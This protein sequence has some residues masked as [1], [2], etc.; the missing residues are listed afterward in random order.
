M[1]NTRSVADI[2]GP[3]AESDWQSG[4]TERC[5]ESW[6]VPIRELSNA[7]LATFLRQD[8]ATDWILEEAISRLNSGFDDDSEK[9]EGELAEKVQEARERRIRRL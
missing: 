2:V 7:T 6:N 3:W 8:I 1:M 4:L 9:Y 5:Q